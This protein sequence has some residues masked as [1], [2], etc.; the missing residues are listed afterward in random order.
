MPD[1]DLG[2]GT[3]LHKCGCSRGGPH[4]RRGGGFAPHER[5]DGATAKIHVSYAKET[6]LGELPST[7]LSNSEER[8]VGDLVV[9]LHPSMQLLKA[10]FDLSPLD[11]YLVCSFPPSQFGPTHEPRYLNNLNIR[12]IGKVDS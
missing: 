2:N 4:N 9:P 12:E 10:K 5:R 1:T 7:T 3:E 8:G 11:L 6:N